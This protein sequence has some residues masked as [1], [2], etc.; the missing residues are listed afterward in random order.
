MPA[1]RRPIAV[2]LD[3]PEPNRLIEGSACQGPSVRTPSYRFYPIGMS[4]QRLEYVS[5][6]DLPELDGLVPVC[7]GKQAPI[8]GKGL[9]RSPVGVPHQD[10]NAG[11]WPGLLYLPE[12]DLPIGAAT[13]EQ[14]SIGPPGASNGKD[15]LSMRH[16]LEKRSPPA[17]P[18]LD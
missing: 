5:T 1:E 17:D 10:R 18:K 9:S 15:S 7:T 6:G 4:D 14:A 13:S 11:C 2:S 3:I 12:P 16:C 8:G